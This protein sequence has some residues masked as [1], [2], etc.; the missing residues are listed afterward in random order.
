MYVSHGL[1]D[2]PHIQV[3]PVIS[4]FDC[5]GHVLP[6]YVRI[7]GVSLKVHK[8]VLTSESTFCILNYRCEVIDNN[9]LKPLKLTYHA[10]EFKW[11]MNK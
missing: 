9:Q 5:N 10:K 11:S 6:L 2:C 4:S 1:N 3:V 8:A 7:N